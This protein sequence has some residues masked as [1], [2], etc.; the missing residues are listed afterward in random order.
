[1]GC[2]K[3]ILKL[4]RTQIDLPLNKSVDFDI[5]AQSIK[6]K[7]GETLGANTLK[8]LFGYKTRQVEPRHS[9]MDVLSRYLGFSDYDALRME[10]GDEAD[11]SMF[12]PIELVEVADLDKGT[13]VRVTYEPNRE[14]ELDY[15]GDCKFTVRNA[16]GSRNIVPGDVMS[17]SQLAIGHRFV[18]AHVWRDGKDLGV[19]EGAK[20]RGITSLTVSRQV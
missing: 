18:A 13:Q 8:R 10:I 15:T 6:D 1:M 16:K 5:L 17:I 2:K 9:T 3:E 20:E 12:S 19:Y 11:I 14:F 7:T 4:V